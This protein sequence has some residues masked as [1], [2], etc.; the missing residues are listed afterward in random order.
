M[1][2]QT[3]EYALRAIVQLA[4]HEGHAQTVQQI[5]DETKVPV[6]YLSKV[7]QALG[8]AK[9]IHS[10][11]GLH[12]GF[13]LVRSPETLTVY[14][15]VGAVDPVQRITTCPLGLEAH[16]TNLCPLHKRLDNAC[17]MVEEAFRSSTIADLLAEPTTSKPLC[18]FPVQ[19]ETAL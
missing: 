14:E 13:T 11:R 6:H 18:P 16:G 10:Q 2:S 4:T 9:L 19:R 7:L 15:I 3:A 12:G 8:R 1:I 5:A 17:L